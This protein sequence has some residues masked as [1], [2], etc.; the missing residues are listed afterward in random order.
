MPRTHNTD[1]VV[2]ISAEVR[3]NVRCACCC[4]WIASNK[5]PVPED[6]DLLIL[7]W[8]GPVQINIEALR[9][10]T[11]VLRRRY[12]YLYTATGIALRGNRPVESPDLVRMGSDLDTFVCVSGCW[13]FDLRQKA[14]VPPNLNL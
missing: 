11:E 4:P 9:R 2:C 13:A 7:H 3:Y 8:V 5:D 1:N 12:R 14:T 10:T 6:P